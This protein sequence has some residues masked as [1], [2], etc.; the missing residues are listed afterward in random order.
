MGET[1][2]PGVKWQALG[3]G[4]GRELGSRE[5][6]ECKGPWKERLCSEQEIR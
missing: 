3:V 2:S 1:A 5:L 6:G 4:Q